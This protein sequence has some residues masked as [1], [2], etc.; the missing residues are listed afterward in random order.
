MDADILKVGEMSPGNCACVRPCFEHVRVHCVCVFVFLFINP[1][2][3][4]NQIR[5]P[6]QMQT[7]LNANLLPRCSDFCYRAREGAR[8]LQPVWLERAC[9]RNF[10]VKCFVIHPARRK[11]SKPQ[12]TNTRVD[13][14]D[15]VR[16]K[17]PRRAR[18]PRMAGGR[19]RQPASQRHSPPAGQPASQPDPGGQQ[20]ARQGPTARMHQNPP[21]SKDQAR[22]ANGNSI[23]SK[24]NVTI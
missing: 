18:L 17:V 14:L 23:F 5:F 13:T 2:C 7:P 19:T 20:P 6:E 9:F 3:T 15:V 22:N 11:P 10:A 16:A 1:R 4:Y 21:E 24:E 8:S 12:L